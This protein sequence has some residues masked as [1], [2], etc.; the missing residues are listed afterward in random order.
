MSIDL[1]LP[2]TAIRRLELLCFAL[3]FLFLSG[4]VYAQSV[5]CDA[6]SAMYRTAPLVGGV[7]DAEDSF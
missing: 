3:I 1:M 4:G 5:S 7:V 6:V 2:R